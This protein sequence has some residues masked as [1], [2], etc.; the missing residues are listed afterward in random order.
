M[1]G[2]FATN[3]RIGTAA[4]LGAATIAWSM[5]VAMPLPAATAPDGFPARRQKATGVD[6][7]DPLGRDEHRYKRIFAL[8]E[9][10]D[11]RRADKLIG[12]WMTVS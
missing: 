5:L 3:Q 9:K 10:G 4:T 8:Q 6:L 7:P 11:W 2:I 12:S 1:Q